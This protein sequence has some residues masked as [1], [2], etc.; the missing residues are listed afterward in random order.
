MDSDYRQRAPAEFETPWL[1]LGLAPAQRRACTLAGM[2]LVAAAAAVATRGLRKPDLAHMAAVAVTAGLGL[3][4]FAAG[5]PPEDIFPGG[6]V[7]ART[8]AQRL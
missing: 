6:V 8:R 2:A 1:H 5:W 4:L 7:L 3:A